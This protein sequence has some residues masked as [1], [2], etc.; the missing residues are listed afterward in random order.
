MMKSHGLPTTVTL[1]IVL[2]ALANIPAQSQSLMHARVS[3]DVG[4][5]MVKG[6]GGGEWSHA[7]V[8]A[9][10][11]PG[12]TLWV[13]QGGTSEIELSGGTFLRMADAS[14]AEVVSL[15]PS[16]TLRGWQGSFY[17]QRLTRST[18]DIVFE[19]P[20]AT[21]D[22]EPDTAVRIDIIEGGATS[23]TVRWG[24]VCA[25]TDAG[26][27]LVIESGYRVW[28]DPGLLP[29]APETFDR[30]NDDDFDV[31]N[32]GRAQ[33]LSG[34]AYTT[35]N[36]VPISESTLGV[37]DLAGNGDWIVV[38]DAT[39]WKPNDSE[40]VPYRSGHWTSVPDRGDV[41]V[42]DYP[43]SY[44][45]SH[46]GYW[47]HHHD[48]GWMWS[49]HREPWSPAWVASVRYGSYYVW[50]PI[51]NHHYP[52]HRYGSANFSVGGLQFGL[53]SSTYASY[54]Y[55]Y[56]GSPYMYSTYHYGFRYPHHINQQVTVWN[57]NVD[58]RDQ[59]PF[60][61]SVLRTRTRMARESVRGP[62]R[63]VANGRSARDRV[64]SLEGRYG[65][66]RFATVARTGG[67]R[68]QT[69]SSVEG[70]VA[71]SRSTRIADVSTRV[72]VPR[73][74]RSSAQMA[75]STSRVTTARKRST[76]RSASVVPRTD[77]NVLIERNRDR[78][79]R[80]PRTVSQGSNRTEVNAVGTSTFRTSRI[81]GSS[82]V[83][84]A[85]ASTLPSSSNGVNRTTTPRSTAQSRVVT[86]SSVARKT[87][88]IRTQTAT[89][90][91]TVSRTPR[92][93]STSGSGRTASRPRVITSSSA[94]RTS[95]AVAT[96]STSVRV[97]TPISNNQATRTAS[98]PRIVTTVSTSNNVARSGSVNSTS[99]T[100][101]FQRSGSLSTFSSRPSITSTRRT[102]P[103]TR[104]PITST[105]RST[106]TTRLP[107][108]NAIPTTRSSQINKPSTRSA[109]SRSRS[110]ISTPSQS[111]STPSPSR[112]SRS[113]TSSPSNSRSSKSSSSRSSSISS[114]S[115]APSRSSSSSSNRSS[116][117][118]RSSSPS[119]PSRGR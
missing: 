57:I 21:I 11:L 47:Q 96:S 70:R 18:G 86:T 58:N 27:S 91:E 103:S 2:G 44:V 81:S 33:F 108:K 13:N 106:T 54:D 111:F 52:S 104:Q 116:R 25:R 80:P 87:P 6:T 16:T 1:A 26:G 75:S 67:R 7:T 88:V 15:P 93:V 24:R 36:A 118:S 62:R 102:T 23:I 22:I 105:R 79:T 28:V 83:T 56:H 37:A 63:L 94:N 119:R 38:D 71:R 14:K 3:Y 31:W 78:I 48:H 53:Y 39:Y 113:I 43:F 60:D 89:P 4:G 77:P 117:S 10:V 19:T 46:H 5:T 65:R 84:T 100:S 73:Q 69:S 76:D 98:R 110:I 92:I 41:W 99:R 17:I 112:K 49:Y 50:S 30:A 109:P 66:D 59:T 107:T 74:G 34:D 115:S 82:T 29:S 64:D 20:A 35:P 40:Y 72:R 95:R 51:D 55:L 85:R 42:G 12:D 45:T 8:N 101:N 114:R 32:R 90:R 61:S 68:A 97:S 9:L